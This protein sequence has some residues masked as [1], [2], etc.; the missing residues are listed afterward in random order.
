MNVRKGVSSSRKGQSSIPESLSRV[1]FFM[2][3]SPQANTSSLRAKGYGFYFSRLSHTSSF[4]PRQSPIL[5]FF[6]PSGFGAGKKKNRKPKLSLSP[7][8]G[9]KRELVWEKLRFF[10]HGFFFPDKSRGKKKT[11]KICPSFLFF[12]TT[13]SFVCDN[14]EK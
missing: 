4:L 2:P 3:S 1:L 10:R 13:D 12:W 7:R 5:R 6:F 11:V 8:L 9:K 14:R